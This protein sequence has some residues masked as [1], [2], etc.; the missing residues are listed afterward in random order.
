M[1]QRMTRRDPP[2]G[3]RRSGYGDSW[4]EEAAFLQAHPGKSYVIQEYPLEE[5]NAARM[6]GVAIRQGRYRAFQPAGAFGASTATEDAHDKQGQL[7]K[8][9]SVYA[10][11]G[12]LSEGDDG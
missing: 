11:F 7:V 2:A 6:L 8:V 4:K 12:E 5:T 3:A 10:W 1:A 9:V